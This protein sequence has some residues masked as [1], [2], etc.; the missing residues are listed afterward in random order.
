MARIAGRR[1]ITSLNVPCRA[2]IVG[3]RAGEQL[4]PAGE[5]RLR[6]VQRPAAAARARR[7]RRVDRPHAS[8]PACASD[9]SSSTR[10]ASSAAAM[11][12]RM[13]CSASR[14]A[15]E[16]RVRRAR[17]C[18]RRPSSIS[19]AT[20]WPAACLACRSW[21]K[22]PQTSHQASTVKK[23]GPTRSGVKRA[24]HRSLTTR[25]IGTR[26]QSASSGRAPQQGGG[27]HLVPVGDDVGGDGHR[28]AHHALHRVVAVR[29]RRARSPRWRCGSPPCASRSTGPAGDAPAM[30]GARP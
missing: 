10:C 17:R 20:F 15:P 5:H 23:C 30:S 3:D 6:P 4:I 22:V 21:R 1:P 26:R 28:V 14:S 27:Q 12:S 18:I 11:S 29:H 9:S 13:R 25:R 7:K 2:R 16:A 24:S 19:S 8:P